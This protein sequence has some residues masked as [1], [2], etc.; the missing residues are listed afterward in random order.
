MYVAKV[1]VLA[2]HVVAKYANTIL[3][4][5][6]G[7]YELRAW[8]PEKD[9]L[10]YAP[11]PPEPPDISRLTLE[12]GEDIGRAMV[13]S[14]E[15]STTIEVEAA[16]LSAGV[17]SPTRGRRRYTILDETYGRTPYP[18]PIVDS[19]GNNLVVV[20]HRSLNQTE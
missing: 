19:K 9:I 1:E 10:A 12:L 4:K 17:G 18:V 2:N 6:P 8:D 13:R 15:N 20:T 3:G 5:G 11:A 14:R 16:H 7:I